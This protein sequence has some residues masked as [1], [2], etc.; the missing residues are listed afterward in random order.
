MRNLNTLHRTALAL[1]TTLALVLPAQANNIDPI[2]TEDL[3]NPAYR[4]EVS[5][6]MGIEFHPEGGSFK[7]YNNDEEFGGY[8]TLWQDEGRTQQHSDY[9]I[10]E[11]KH[12][13]A[14][15]EKYLLLDEADRGENL[16][17]VGVQ[18][19]WRETDTTDTSVA[20]NMPMEGIAYV[21]F[22]D[23]PADW[24]P[25]KQAILMGCGAFVAEWTGPGQELSDAIE[26]QWW[27]EVAK[28]ALTPLKTDVGYTYG[29]GIEDLNED[30]AY[31]YEVSVPEGP[32]QFCKAGDEEL[33]GAAGLVDLVENQDLDRGTAEIRWCNQS[34]LDGDSKIEGLAV[35]CLT[36]FGN[37]ELPL[38][39]AGM[40]VIGN[41]VDFGDDFNESEIAQD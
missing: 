29:F 38:F 21:C 4:A 14:V 8:Y 7:L 36:P 16:E 2:N 41:A 32:S 34:E 24:R 28:A 5:H 30:S 23:I 39:C 27:D 10:V 20:M 13:R 15:F 25:Y 11:P 3:S 17:D 40:S 33:I 22:R 12:I 19:D 9:S 31:T 35:V 37:G 1:C 18:F 26:G 6:L